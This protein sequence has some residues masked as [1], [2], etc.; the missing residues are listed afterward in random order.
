MKFDRSFL[1]GIFMGL[2]LI[3]FA[4]SRTISGTIL[5]SET[6]S[7]LPGVTI[8]IKGAGTGTQT[9]ELGNFSLQASSGDVLL[10]SFIGFASQEILISDQNNLTLLLIPETQNLDEVVVIGYGTQSRRNITSAI[11]KLDNN[12]LA[13][14]P[15]ANVGS[16]LQGSLPGLQVVNLSGQPGAI[17]YILLRGGA[18]INNPGA[19]LVVIDGIIRAFND[20]APD[21]IASIELLKDAASTAIY[22]ARA[23]NGVILIT[24]KQGKA[25]TS[26]I[27][28]KFNAGFNQR[29]Q[30]YNY[31]G[32]KDFIY[33]T[34][35]GHLN[36]KRTL[37][38]ANSSRGFGLLT[39][40]ANLASFDIRSFNSDNANLL[41]Q[42]WDTLSDPYGGTIIFKDHQGEVEDIV[43]QNT[44][45]QDHY[46]SA[47]GGNDR[48]NYFA[49][50]N[51]YKEDGVIV[52][53]DY[54]RYTGAING[55]YKLRKNLEVNTG[56][57][58]SNSGQLGVNG[59]EVNN[60]YR[61]LSI[62]P[63]FNPWL[64]E[65][66]T[67]PNPGNG[68]N[69]GNPLYWL[70]KLQRSNEINRITANASIKYDILPG[71]YV[72]LS[73]NGYF[74]E[75]QN[76][77]F[78]KA[79][80]SYLNLFA[81]PPSFSNTA[82]TS[83]L[84]ISKSFQQTYNGI[85]NYTTT[86]ARDHNITAMIGAEHYDI[87]STFLQIQGSKAPTDDIPTA[88]A[89]TEFTPAGNTVSKSENKIISTFGRLNYNFKEKYLLT[90]VFRQDG[91]SSL[92]AQN[93]WGFFPGL[94]A[95]WLVDQESF[96]Q[97]SSLS[98]VISSLKPRISYG[99]NGNVNGIGNYDVQGVYGSQGNYNGQG[100]FL[101]TG[102]VNNNLIWEKS[103]TLDI[104]VDL[105]I[106]K[107]KVIFLFDYFNR[108]TSDL[109]TGL[110]LPSY[111]GFNSVTTNLGTYQNRGIELAINANVIQSPK[112][113]TW[114]IGANASLV[115][116]NILQLPFNGN[117]NNRQGGLQ[118]YDP[119]SKQV[120]WVGGLQE[121]RSLGDI[122]A[123][124][125][126]SIFKDDAEVAAIAGNR[127]D[128]V[129]RISGPE[130][131]NTGTNKITPGDVNWRDVDKNDTIDSRDQIKIGNINPKWTGGFTSNL[132]YKGISLYTR[133]EYA[134]GHTIYN[135]LVAR[136]LGNYQ[137]T[138]NYIDW[139]NRAWS[140]TNT[141]TDIPKVYF[142][143]QVTAPNGKQ[144]YTR[145][146]NASTALNSNNS[147]FYEKGNYLAIRE[148]TLSYDLPKS[149]LSGT[150]VLS[151]ARLYINANNL[152][153]MTKFSGLTPE[154]AYSS[155]GVYVG[156]Y[157]TPKSFV[158]GLQ[159]SF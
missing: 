139:Q 14:A 27:S 79:T 86:L 81:N 104:G 11:A 134:T 128:A 151:Q 22:G 77:S 112:G 47:T 53:S 94:S 3:T 26:Q 51:Y 54:K 23:N 147:H 24:T 115:K 101:N 67:K 17:P 125:Q 124:E 93:R 157:P 20:I 42:G 117:E 136:T 138:F 71:L 114:D 31:L 156:T 109:L 60:I 119:V 142:A 80:Q 111:T 87:N 143:D 155:G 120:I 88:N 76:E 38:Q 39:D 9:D 40:A 56:A 28:Y 16:A 50:F 36:S 15:R 25:G 102:L 59:S 89:S 113:L 58:F 145:G 2:S 61:N 12:V 1:I 103:K 98:K 107:N 13:N 108:E 69:D 150:K 97:K 18:S 33:Y 19:P 7:G 148:I 8:A 154:P 83:T 66:K 91:V 118:V 49:S 149:L 57:N 78:Q 29:R 123:Y 37:A 72:K 152:V 133:F 62:W 70:D 65:A 137:G 82:R 131:N 99:L 6:N 48:G 46:L 140:P 35:L 74:F 126:V 68:I 10:I 64:D 96:F 63:T 129:A 135:D 159:A 92:A 121:G 100:G 55:S 41:T 110:T 85:I 95:G 75:N 73:G 84:S 30:G 32:A 127:Y 105:G 4:Q 141:N 116:N 43:F 90:L 44:Q 34:R 130:R 52:G 146:N 122:Y 106:L 158:F 153:Y 21:D 144:N 5:D 132:G 45:T